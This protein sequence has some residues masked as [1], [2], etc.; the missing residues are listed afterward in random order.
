[1]PFRTGAPVRS[2]QTPLQAPA[3]RP[4]G[5]H[6]ARCSGDS[7]RGDG[8]PTSAS[9]PPTV[10]RSSFL[11]LAAS[12]TAAVMGGWWTKFGGDESHELPGRGHGRAPEPVTARHA[13][14]IRPPDAGPPP[15][16]SLAS[17][18]RLLV[19]LLLPLQLSI[20][21]PPQ[22]WPTI[23]GRRRCA[24]PSFTP[25]HSG[26]RADPTQTPA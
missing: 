26:L 19:A 18:A 2:A 23:A 9:T 17:K 5:R 11:L 3:A 15:L 6:C 13:G 25:A 7:T 1:M 16:P 24:L 14:T 4:P 21:T 10:R 8:R 12:T 22:R 20:L